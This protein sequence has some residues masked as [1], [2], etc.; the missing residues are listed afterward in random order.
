MKIDAF[1]SGSPMGSPK[2]V[3]AGPGTP[4]DPKTHLFVTNRVAIPPFWTSGP[5]FYAEF[6]RGSR[7]GGPTPSI[8]T[9]FDHFWHVFWGKVDFWPEKKRPCEATPPRSNRAWKSQPPG[10]PK[11]PFWLNKCIF[12]QKMVKQ[13]VEFGGDLSGEIHA[14]ILRILAPRMC[15]T[16]GW[17]PNW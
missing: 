1:G 7:Q 17:R 10:G 15:K 11:R 5:G 14:E 6:W 4:R 9:F 12:G 3:R 13:K 8:S 2:G 16:V